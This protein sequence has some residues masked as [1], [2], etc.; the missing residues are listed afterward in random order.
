METFK[1]WD[2]LTADE[3]IERLHHDLS[4]FIERSEEHQAVRH[5]ALE[6]VKAHLAATEGEL[7]RIAARLARLER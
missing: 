2:Q 4:R 5:Q 1:P 6:A 3:K 7:K